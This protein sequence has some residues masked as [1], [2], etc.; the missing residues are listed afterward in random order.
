MGGDDFAGAA[1]GATLGALGRASG[2]GSPLRHPRR[3]G[4][5]NVSPETLGAVGGIKV[6]IKTG[7]VPSGGEEAGGDILPRGSPSPMAANRRTPAL[8][9]VSNHRASRV[10]GLASASSVIPQCDLS[11]WAGTGTSMSFKKRPNS[12]CAPRVSGGG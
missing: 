1:G 6:L 5:G 3:A 4:I 9:R 8:G 2:I 10:Y 11:G 12:D 7:P